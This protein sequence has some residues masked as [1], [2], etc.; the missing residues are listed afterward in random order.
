MYS[1]ADI[2]YDSNWIQ[3]PNVEESSTSVVSD[4]HPA[5]W[6]SVGDRTTKTSSFSKASDSF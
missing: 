4:K 5:G 2:F 3:L 6:S 1:S